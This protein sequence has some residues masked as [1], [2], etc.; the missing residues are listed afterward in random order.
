MSRFPFGDT[1]FQKLKD[2]LRVRQLRKLCQPGELV[3]QGY[4]RSGGVKHQGKQIWV[5]AAIV[6]PED[7]NQTR[8][9]EDS[10]NTNVK[11]VGR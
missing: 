1:M 10:Q 5:R 6:R 2:F 11:M 4:W 7:R 8:R 9:S 3:R